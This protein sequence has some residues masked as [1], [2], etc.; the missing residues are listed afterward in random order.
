MDISPESLPNLSCFDMFVKN[1]GSKPEVVQGVHKF[2][3]D[4]IVGKEQGQTN[5]VFI[6]LF[7]QFTK[8]PVKDY[9]CSRMTKSILLDLT[10]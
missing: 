5:S 9:V 10:L 7:N 3:L 6:G 2:L 1:P 8:V 4:V